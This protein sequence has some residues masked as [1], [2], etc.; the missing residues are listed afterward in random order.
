MPTG[1]KP[2]DKRDFHVSATRLDEY[3]TC[4]RFYKL[5][6]IDKVEEIPAHP[7]VVGRLVHDFCRLYDG[8]LVQANLKTDLSMVE[9]IVNQVLSLEREGRDAM[10]ITAEAA[11]EAAELM[12]LW[13]SRHVLQPETVYSLE[14]LRWIQMGPNLVFWYVID[15]CQTEGKTATITD[16]KTDRRIWPAHEIKKSPQLRNYAWAVWKEEPWLE[17]FRL[18]L[19]FVRFGYVTEPMEFSL[20]DIRQHETELMAQIARMRQDTKFEPTP[21]EGCSFCPGRADC[22]ALQA[23]GA[24]VITSEDQAVQVY[25]KLLVLEAEVKTIKGYLQKWCQLNGNVQ[26][27]GSEIGYW[28][29]E[30]TQVHPK[31]LRK[32]IEIVGDRDQNPFDFLAVP[33]ASLKRL[34]KDEVMAEAL[35]PVLQTKAYTRFASKKASDDEGSEEVAGS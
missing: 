8:H 33:A 32:F 28:K 3:S 21:G 1:R 15:L 11:S 25:G 5:R 4:P 2:Y 17:S 35:E 10:H 29:S 31:M 9:P 13:A 6:R 27:I 24:T 26:A 19:D 14:E 30:T 20:D 22:P 7:L 34:L 18:S 23:A 16:Y 12:R